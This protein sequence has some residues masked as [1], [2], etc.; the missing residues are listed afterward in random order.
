M[1][2]P[3]SL[4]QTIGGLGIFL[5]GMIVMTDAL[6]SMAG[7]S[8]RRS[9]MHFTRSPMTGAMTGA[10]STAVLQSSSATTVATIGFV[11]AGLISFPS[12]IGVILGANLGTTITGWIVALVG[13]K[14]KLATLLLP[15]VLIG[16]L[17]RLFFSGRLSHVGLALAGFALIFV[18]ID[19]MQFGMQ[20]L[21]GALSDFSLPADAWEGRLKLICL[22]LIFT[23]VTQSSSAGVAAVLTALFTDTI[24]L[25][26]GLTLVIGMNIGTT[27]TALMATIGRS[28]NTKRTGYS[29]VIFNVAVGVGALL[30]VDPYVTFWEHVAPGQ[31]EKN[32]EL[33]LV[34]FHTLFNLAGVIMFLPFTRQFAIL[35][36]QL[37]PASHDQYT[38][39]LDSMHLAEPDVAL[40]ALAASVRQEFMALLRHLRSLI[41]N[42]KD[43]VDLRQLKVALDETY[44]FA[45]A[46]RF[47]SDEPGWR[48]LVSLF[49]TLDHLKRLHERCTTEEYRVI[50]ARDAEE[51]S[52]CCD[53]LYQAAANVAIDISDGDWSAAR[54]IA[55]SNLMEVRAFVEPF[56]ESVMLRVADDAL[57]TLDANR[58]LEAIRWLSRV[59]YH[60]SHITQHIDIASARFEDNPV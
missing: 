9:L 21:E 41:R 10:I 43:R 51:L 6:T 47:S 58:L 49:H 32:A 14:L 36:E 29:H 5:V 11:G 17:M 3:V 22:G 54:E 31:I 37:V 56:R 16:G 35:L 52:V 55:E 4:L 44:R 38:R 18:G 28:T 20:G 48:E 8:L 59:S 2:S 40:S 19:Q 7:D 50:A 15:L 39:L 33:I 26:Q 30:M 27:V 25:S 23:V 53:R 45:D 42:E 60:I 34:G 57:S 13:F 46:I 1:D 12:A 24:S